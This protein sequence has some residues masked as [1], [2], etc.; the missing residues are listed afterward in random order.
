MGILCL[1]KTYV[2][3]ALVNGIGYKFFSMFTSFI[4]FIWKHI[5]LIL[6]LLLRPKY[7]YNPYLNNNPRLVKGLRIVKQGTNKRYYSTSSKTLVERKET[8]LE[9]NPFWV[10]GFADGEACFYVGVR[11]STKVSIGWRI[12][13]SF[14]INL[15]KRDK[16]VLELISNLLG[17]GT[18][19]PQGSG[20]VQ[21]RI[22]SMKEI[23]VVISHFQKFPLLTEKLADFVLFKEVYNIIINKEH[24]TETGLRKIVARKASMNNGLSL[25]LTSVFV[26][27]TPVNRPL[28]LDKKIKDPYWLAGFIAAEGCFMIN[29]TKLGEG[30]YVKLLFIISQHERDKGLLYSF[31]DYLG[32][33]SV[34]KNKDTFDY[35]VS[36]FADIEEKILPFLKNYPLKGVKS[37][38]FEDW[39]LVAGI[40]KDK[41]HLTPKGLEQIKQIKARMNKGRKEI[42]KD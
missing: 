40:I 24:L 26:D 1:L 30:S 12:T 5:S 9:L 11:K 2:V 33:G 3:I 28:V 17:V 35:R 39:A 7:K 37:K 22:F 18:I 13:L 19:Y 41:K 25:T 38:D 15:H 32:C 31:I 20:L 10:T 23:E 34:Y 29:I 21:L 16:A 42:T 36:K 14:T 8:A 27:V 6:S 4:T